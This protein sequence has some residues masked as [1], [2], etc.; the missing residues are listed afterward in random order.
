M[1]KESKYNTK[2]NFNIPKST[3]NQQNELVERIY[4]YGNGTKFH[5]ILNQQVKKKKY[6]PIITT[7]LDEAKDIQNQINRQIEKTGK[8]RTENQ[9]EMEQEMKKS[10]L[11]KKFGS[12]IKKPIPQFIAEEEEQNNYEKRHIILGQEIFSI[13][14]FKALGSLPPSNGQRDNAVIPSIMR[15]KIFTEKER[16]TFKH[17]K[18]TKG[19]TQQNLINNYNN[20]NEGFS[21]VKPTTTI[22]NLKDDSK[23]VNYLKAAKKY[24]QEYVLDFETTVNNVQ[25]YENYQD[26]NKDLPPSTIKKEETSDEYQYMNSIQNFIKEAFEGKDY[27]I[28]FVYYLPSNKENYYELRLTEFAHIAEQKV[29]YTLSQKGLMVYEDKQPKEFIKLSEWI[30]EKEGYNF[31]A[32]I[33]FFKNFKIW[34]IIKIWRK[35]I[36]KQKKIAYQNEL[37]NKLLFNNPDYN[38]K[39]N[40]HKANCNNILKLKILNMS[41]GYESHNFDLFKTKQEKERLNLKTKL[42]NIH[43]QSEVIFVEGIKKIFSKLHKEIT[44]E[45]NENNYSDTKKKTAV[46]ANL[47]NKKNQGKNEEV[48]VNDGGA[49]NEETIVGFENFSFKYKMKIKTECMNFIKLAYL[50]DYILLDCLRTMFLF[51]IKDSIDKLK[52]FNNKETPN[53]IRE[54][55]LTKRDEYVKPVTQKTGDKTIPYFIVNCLINQITDRNQIE[56][57]HLNKINIKPFFFKSSFDEEFKPAAHIEIFDEDIGLLQTNTES[58]QIDKLESPHIYFTEYDPPKEKIKEEFSNQIQQSI[59]ALRIFGWK[60]HP[61]FKKYLP[62]LGDYDDRYGDWD[63]DDK[64]PQDPSSILNNDDL[65]MERDNQI[66]EEINVAYKKCENYMQM[67]N[68]LFQLHWDILCIEKN[69]LLDENI[70]EAD[71][72]YRLIFTL[73]ERNIKTLQRYAPFEEDIGMVKLSFENNMRMDLIKTQEQ[74]LIFIKENVPNILKSRLRYIE[75]WFGDML[76]EIKGKVETAKDFLQKNKA[77]DEI[78]KLYSSY[79]RKISTID[80]ILNLFKKKNFDNITPEDLNYLNDINQL[81]Y[82]LK[83]SWDDLN[84]TLTK[85]RVDLSEDLKT[86]K[87][88]ELN[89]KADYLLNNNIREPKYFEYTEN[90]KAHISINIEE[91]TGHE[92]KCGELYSLAETYNEFFNVIGEGGYPFD[93]VENA[94][95]SVEALKKLWIS[96]ELFEADCESWKA[97]VMKGVSSEEVL[98]KIKSYQVI[99]RK[100]SNAFPNDVIHSIMVTGQ[101]DTAKQLTYRSIID[102][103]QNNVN[104]YEELIHVVKDL[105]LIDGIKDAAGEKDSDKALKNDYKR[106]I[107]DII[108]SKA[109]PESNM[110]IVFDSKDFTVEDLM[111]MNA[112]TQRQKIHD[113]VVE[114]ISCNDLISRW[115]KIRDQF[116]NEAVIL[117]EAEIK[118]YY[119]L[120]DV[121]SL[122]ERIE[123]IQTKLNSI[124]ASRYFKHIPEKDEADVKKYKKDTEIFLDYIE[125][126]KSFQK[127]FIYLAAIII[128]GDMGKKLP[129]LNFDKVD[130]PFKNFITNCRSQNINFKVQKIAGENTKKGKG[131]M[132]FKEGLKLLDEIQIKIERHLTYLRNEIPRL[133]FISNDDLL[134]ILSNFKVENFD[135]VKP[136]L[137][138]LFDDIVDL[139]FTAD[140]TANYKLVIGF[141]SQGKEELLFINPKSVTSENFDISKEKLKHFKL[142]DDL[143]RTLS[144]IE[145]KMTEVISGYLS[146]RDESNILGFDFKLWIDKLPSQIIA[147]LSHVNFTL[148]TEAA[149]ISYQSDKDA[150]EEFYNTIQTEIKAF[151]S[152]VNKKEYSKN[153]R[154]TISNF[155]THHVH[156]REICIDLGKEDEINITDFIWQKVLRAYIEKDAGDTSELRIKQLNAVFNYGYEYNGPNTRLVISGLTDRVWLT[157]TQALSIKAGCSLGG[158]AGTGKT[159]TTKDLAR[160]LGYQCIVFNCSEQITFKILANIFCG[161]CLHRKGAFACLDEFNRI[162]VEVLSV[163]AQYLLNIKIAQLEGRS[164]VTILKEIDLEGKLGV[165]ITMNPT[166]SGRTELPDNLKSLFRPISMMVPDFETIAEVKLYSEGF[167]TAKALSKK[168]TKLYE[169]A[170]KQLSQQDHYDFT[171]RTVGSVLSIAGTLKRTN[172]S[173]ASSASGPALSIEAEEE[174]MLIKALKDANIPKFL[175]EDIKLFR[176]LLF[177]LFP[178]VDPKE[179]YPI[180]LKK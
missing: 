168:L 30:I 80:S 98:D 87:I 161:L 95:S 101:T 128:T 93:N 13:T 153:T 52:E 49:V 160:F 50:F 79:E 88:D 78:E 106:R 42:T 38:E 122:I 4:D 64:V 56:S 127:K 100:A 178:D 118:E 121:D 103:F 57:R 133:Y 139:K 3:N 90:Y 117:I 11:T 44:T 20:T 43:E 140:S 91:L 8:F 152:I 7:E 120:Q 19:F 170:G 169:L 116:N 146:S 145:N 14:G 47:K 159:E 113:I 99:V 15:H 175:N 82:K 166:Y 142:E 28:N 37:A 35:N 23:G 48:V 27:K 109:P 71:E 51:S 32:N 69:I 164:K 115:R 9:V 148:R 132:D 55:V 89:N 10:L 151:A 53:E 24:L 107:L 167:I 96:I 129:D 130:S 144:A 18:T 154:K 67:M 137:S 6:R 58:I 75:K 66:Q 158:P 162:N 45:N 147:V 83:L 85:A 112:H 149:I 143:T 59:D 177:D 134:F 119:I 123:D 29:Y 179:T 171:L 110:K 86:K 63:N 125:D 34:R 60:G 92:K 102:E 105:C 138:K 156:N 104:K 124:I 46:E 74:L 26:A 70:K 62:Y 73:V 97:L 5:D 39:L 36:F 165:F 76:K 17:L 22:I 174:E 131:K 41:V 176:A 68:P 108:A 111:V 2:I 1:D 21:L 180:E 54:N 136:Y 25:N 114:A 173:S 33:N 81:K 12:K 72:V 65:F 84:E 16:D 163:V 77:K 61:E 135:K 141:I 126:W 31:V 157:I 94:K 172:V 155:I 150:M 40:Q